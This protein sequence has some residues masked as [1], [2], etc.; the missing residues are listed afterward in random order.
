[1]K[2]N[3]YIKMKTETIK[4]RITEKDRETIDKATKK[5]HKETG[6]KSTISGM[7]RHLVTQYTTPQAKRV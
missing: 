3:K 5:Y 6:A 1:M 2:T 7:I 4:V